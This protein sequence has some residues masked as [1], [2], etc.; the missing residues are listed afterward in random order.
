M[1]SL[2][3][4]WGEKQFEDLRRG[5]ARLVLPQVS[6]EEDFEIELSIPD[7]YSR[8]SGAGHLSRYPEIS[9]LRGSCFSEADGKYKIRCKIFADG[10]ERSYGGRYLRIDDV[11]GRSVIRGIE[12]GDVAE[13]AKAIECGPFEFELRACGR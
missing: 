1:S 10:T 3:Q 11:G 5:L 12:G 8:F 4:G 13:G 7:E 9:A 2:K 6:K